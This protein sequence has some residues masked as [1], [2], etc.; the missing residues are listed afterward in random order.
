MIGSQ[1][2]FCKALERYDGCDMPAIRV[3]CGAVFRASSAALAASRMTDMSHM[4]VLMRLWSVRSTLAMAATELHM[5]QHCQQGMMYPPDA[6]A[7][8]PVRCAGPL[9]AGLSSGAELFTH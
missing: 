2:S 1:R 3:H 7:M 8:H 4:P 9:P 5:L 6:S